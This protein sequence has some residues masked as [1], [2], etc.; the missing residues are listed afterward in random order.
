M[1]N[2]SEVPNSRSVTASRPRRRLAPEQRRR[3]IVDA[4]TGLIA[5]SGYAGLTMAR[6]AE[7]CGMTKAGLMYYFPNRESLLTAVLERRDVVDLLKI[8][9]PA[10]PVRDSGACREY[11]TRLVRRNADQPRIVQLYTVLSAEALDPEHPAHE[12][13]RHRL[14]TARASL[15]QNLFA[16][17]PTPELCATQ[18]LAFLD[19][20]QLNWLRDPT[21]D[22]LAEWEAFADRFFHGPDSAGRDVH[23]D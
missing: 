12:Y 18:L 22:L 3:E 6:F 2:R 20:A 8:G 23:T 14:V 19:G 10:Q 1:A 15:S 4:A 13:F 17:H 7:A 16:W 9:L 21:I 5:N 11:L